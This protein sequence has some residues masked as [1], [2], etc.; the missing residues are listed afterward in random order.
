[1][2]GYAYRGNR[3]DTGVRPSC[4]TASG[5]R[6]HM[7]LNETTCDPCKAAHRED[8]AR[9]RPRKYT[10]PPE[11]GTMRAWHRH[12]RRGEIPCLPCADAKSAYSR[13]W[14]ARQKQ[15]KQVST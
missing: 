13:E 7:R 10:Q 11:H 15:D 14:R 8:M 3:P 4:G 6:Q 1:M 9:Y 5:Y 12:R 2:S